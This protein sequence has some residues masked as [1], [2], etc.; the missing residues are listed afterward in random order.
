[1]KKL[2][3]LLLA[4][5]LVCCGLALAEEAE[6]SS[7]VG[8]KMSECSVPRLPATRL[9]S[10]RVGTL[11]GPTTIGLVEL[12]D[13]A[14]KGEAELPYAFAMDT[15][16]AFIT[17]MASGE[18]D[19]VT[20]PANAA[21]IWYNKLQGAVKVVDINTLGVL[22]IVAAQDG[23]TSMADLAGKTLALTGKG[24]SPEW[25]LRAL[26]AANGIAEDDVTLEYKSEATEVMQALVSGAADLALL[27]Q[28]FVT[29]ACA[30]NESLRV[31]LDMTEEWTKAKPDS[32]LCTGV[33]VVRAA[34]LEE[35]PEAVKAFLADHAQSAAFANEHTAEAAAL[36]AAAGIIEKAPV[37]E[38]A[39][40]KC[41]IV[42]L[43]GEEMKS[44]LSGYL[45]ALFELEP[46]AVGG[47]LPDD[48]FYYVG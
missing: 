35:H 40:P 32:Q 37:A 44:A 19:I 11:K 17:Q 45:K 8:T 20:I 26:L 36:V 10:V 21:A 46:S 38:K 4:L 5:C 25:V 9:E 42:C 28:P 15:A 30:Q 23:V 24:T 33:T 34:F 27:P 47:Q 13:R 29:A 2:L 22:Y 16:D 39:I 41:N 18:I 3:A 31:V 6:E 1:M 14:E 12:M 48:G 43:S 7:E